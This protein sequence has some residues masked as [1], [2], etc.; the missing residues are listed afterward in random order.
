MPNATGL[1]QCPDCGALWKPDRSEVVAQ[2]NVLKTK[3]SRLINRREKLVAGG[4]TDELKYKIEY[5]D[6]KNSLFATDLC[7]KALKS[8]LQGNPVQMW[9]MRYEKA[10]EVAKEMFGEQKYEKFRQ[11]VT[12]ACR[13]KLK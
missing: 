2:L 4:M 11:A 13:P 8:E 6:I 7:I 9:Q 5:S 1:C 10:M 3:Y 12:D